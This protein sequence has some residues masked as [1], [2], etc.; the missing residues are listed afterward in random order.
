MQ[1]LLKRA[2]RGNQAYGQGYPGKIVLNNSGD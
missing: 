1:F 2:G